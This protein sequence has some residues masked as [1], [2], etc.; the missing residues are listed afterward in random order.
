MD[1]TPREHSQGPSGDMSSQ[2][3][4]SLGLAGSLDPNEQQLLR[5][6]LK[7]I[8]KKPYELQPYLIASRLYK[9]IGD[10]DNYRKILAQGSHYFPN[11][12]QLQVHTLRTFAC[13]NFVPLDLS[14]L[15]YLFEH[16]QLR[17][18]QYS[19]I[20]ISITPLTNQLRPHDC[21]T[22]DCS[23]AE[24]HLLLHFSTTHIL[25][26]KW[27]TM[28]KHAPIDSNERALGRHTLDLQY[29]PPSAHHLPRLSRTTSAQRLEPGGIA[30]PSPPH[31]PQP[32]HPP[33]RTSQTTSNPYLP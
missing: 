10:I 25:R 24:K 8:K 13:P 1:L 19:C 31:S 3:G 2:N 33:P 4:L 30:S 5:L 18:I 28:P 27:W 26:A 11:N 16:F 7:R 9:S 21:M 23:R 14:C 29:F 32:S 20:N 6:N 17:L 15:V 22:P 12:P